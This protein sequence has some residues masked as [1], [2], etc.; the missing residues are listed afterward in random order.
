MTVDENDKIYFENKDK[1][2]KQH[3]FEQSLAAK[4]HDNRNKGFDLEL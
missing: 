3:E 4:N 1:R 2:I